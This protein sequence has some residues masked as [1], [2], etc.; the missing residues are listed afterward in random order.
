MII[1][2]DET[3]QDPPQLGSP[4]GLAAAPAPMLVPAGAQP[5]SATGVHAA[6]MEISLLSRL[7]NLT[8]LLPT[9]EHP[10]IPMINFSQRPNLTDLM[11]FSPM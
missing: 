5:V 2:K 3:P 11:H 6:L 10:S 8:I 4:A 7:E 9:A 1:K